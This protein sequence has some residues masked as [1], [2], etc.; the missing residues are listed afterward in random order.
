[1]SVALRTARLVGASV[2]LLPLGLAAQGAS[3]PAKL[4]PRPTAGPI[5]VPD[6]M[7][8]LYRVADDSMGGRPTGSEGHAKVTQYI[9]DELRRLGLQPAGDNG[10]YFQDI[11]M[12]R[13][14]FAT[15]SSVTPR[16]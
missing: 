4:P 8:R 11:G 1:M 15:N 5:S 16:S 13:R 3:L 2:L 7:T 12:T 9:A 14:G 10:S 6:L